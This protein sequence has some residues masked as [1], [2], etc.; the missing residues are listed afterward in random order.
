MSA[1]SDAEYHAHPALSYSTG[2]EYLRSP[3]HYKRALSHRVDKPAFDMGHAIHKVILGKGGQMVEIPADIL[4]KN[5]ALSTAEA[6]AFVAEQRE[7]GNIPLKAGQIMQAHAAAAEV[8]GN[9]DARRYL[10]LPGEAEVPLFATDPA[11]GVEI[12]GKVD[13][14]PHKVKG[15]RTFPVDIK[16]TADASPEAVR[17]TISNLHYDLQAAMY[18][19]LIELARGDRTGP[20]VQIWVEVE[21]PYGVLVVQIAHEDWIE[22]GNRKLDLIL[23]RHAEALRTGNWHAYPPGTHALAPPGFYLPGIDYLEDITA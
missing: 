9:A 6:K 23:A 7:A 12:R 4:S 8:L 19:R 11:T 10:D 15:A 14:L 22:G 17:R 20:M 18:R 5:G 21:P 2:K 1:L 13:Y 3:A 16:S